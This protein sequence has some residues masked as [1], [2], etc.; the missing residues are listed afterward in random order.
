MP[1]AILG[2][3]SPN[4]IRNHE[5]SSYTRA[6]LYEIYRNGAISAVIANNENI[7][8]FTVLIIFKNTIINYYASSLYRS[9]KSKILND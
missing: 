2:Q 6:I 5:Y 3:L 9:G 1:R 4:H 7:F 8:N